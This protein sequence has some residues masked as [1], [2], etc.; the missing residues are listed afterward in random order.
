MNRETSI[1]LPTATHQSGFSSTISN[2]VPDLLPT[3]PTKLS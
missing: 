1:A 3:S 2:G